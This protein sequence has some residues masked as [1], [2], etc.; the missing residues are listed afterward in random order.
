MMRRR[1]LPMVLIAAV[2]VTV[3]GAAFASWTGGGSGSA[4][5]AAMSM[6]AGPTPIVGAVGRTVTVTW[7]SVHFADLTDVN[8]YLVTRYDTNDVAQSVGASCAGAIVALTC[9][10]TAVP[11]GVWTYTLTPKQGSWLG[12]E[13]AES[14]PVTV[15]PASLSFSG[16]TILA[17]LP[18]VLSGSVA[19]FLPGETVTY[20]LDDPSTGPILAGSLTPSPV[21]ATGTSAMTVTIPVLVSAG[22]HTVY[23]IGSVGSQ[24][25]GTFTVLPHD[26]TAP[27]VS[28]AIIGKSV[29][30]IG[31]YL[32]QGA[33]YHIY[34]NPIDLGSPAIGLSTV[35]ANVSTITSGATNVALNLGVYTFQGVAYTHRSA[36]Q[37]ASNPLAAGV[38]NFTITATDL[39]GNSASPSFTATVDNTVPTATDVQTVNVGGGTNGKAE[40]GDTITFTY[41]EPMDP[42]SILAGWNGSS[43]AVTLRLIQNGGGDR[44]EI[45]NALNLS[46]LPLGL[47]RLNRTDYTT[48][49][50]SFVTST[51]VMSGS[52]ITITLGV[53]GGATTTAA[54]NGAM[55]LTPV[56]TATDRAAN[57]INVAVVPTESGAADKDF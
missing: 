45:W 36:I 27:T 55:T 28:S 43:T 48:A 14:S 6:P 11:P 18:S 37:T 32:K 24:A 38:K 9:A 35:R 51:M 3:P 47:T 33:Q 16:S 19:S 34:A 13:S 5:G 54:G 23:A 42:Y 56:A 29:G 25:S 8:A 7:S 2:I 4:Y 22:G 50:V 26:V 40:A 21:P 39:L 12:A 10:E 46:Q 49:T 30:G 17:T 31:G 53:P 44:V 57:A 20:R 52:T 15:D 41:S 1:L